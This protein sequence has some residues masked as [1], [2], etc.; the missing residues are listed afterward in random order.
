MELETE[1]DSKLSANSSLLKNVSK[2][3]N[4]ANF[5]IIYPKNPDLIGHALSGTEYRH[6]IETSKSI[7]EHKLQAGIH[8][9][10]FVTFPNSQIFKT[11]SHLFLK[12]NGEF[13][14]TRISGFSKQYLYVFDLS[15]PAYMKWLQRS[16]HTIVKKWKF[17]YIHLLG[18]EAAD[19]SGNAYDSAQTAYDRLYLS[20]RLMSKVAGKK[21]FFTAS[22]ELLWPNVLFIDMLEIEATGQSNGNY[23]Q[24]LDNLLEKIRVQACINSLSFPCL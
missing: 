1:K 21:V 6:V 16:I 8:F 3:R 10:P 12:K 17:S 14:R 19:I 23:S 20:L 2:Y 4:E 9:S 15:H 5:F 24:K 18:L 22:E 11:Q 13:V 7:H